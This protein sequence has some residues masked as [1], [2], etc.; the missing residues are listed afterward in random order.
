MVAAIAILV[1][2]K[3]MIA[4]VMVA[5]IAGAAIA[6]A[7]GQGRRGQRQRAGYAQDSHVLSP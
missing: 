1:A 4:A 5:I 3:V 2:P 7:A 6:M